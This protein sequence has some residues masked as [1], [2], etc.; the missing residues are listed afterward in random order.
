M[1]DAEAEARAWIEL[2][3]IGRDD[4]GAPVRY[5]IAYLV[6]LRDALDESRARISE[7]EAIVIA[8][9]LEITEARA[10]IARLTAPPGSSAMERARDLLADDPSELDEEWLAGVIEQAERE[11]RAAAVKE[12]AIWIAP[13]FPGQARDMV[14]ALAIDNKKPAGAG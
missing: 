3:T 4:P 14:R 13:N 1:T 6:T 7:G 5:D 9:R 10:E 11:A 2:N 8:Q 12:C